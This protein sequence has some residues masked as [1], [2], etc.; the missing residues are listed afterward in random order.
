M[1]PSSLNDTFRTISVRNSVVAGMSLSTIVEAQTLSNVQGAIG[2]VELVKTVS[3]WMT[4]TILTKAPIIQDPKDPSAPHSILKQPAGI[5]FRRCGEEVLQKKSQ[6]EKKFLNGVLENLEVLLRCEKRRKLHESENFEVSIIDEKHLLS[7]PKDKRK[8]NT[9]LG[10]RGV[11]AKQ[12]IRAGSP[13]VYSAQY[14]NEDQWFA[15]VQGL[16]GYLAIEFNLCPEDACLEAAQRLAAYAFPIVEFQSEVFRVP[17]YGAGNVCVMINHDETFFNMKSFRPPLIDEKGKPVA[18]VT[19]YY[20]C[21][22]IEQGEQLLVNYG[23]KYKIQR[24]FE[25]REAVHF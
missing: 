3:P 11:I 4:D 6:R 13:V 24:F 8:L 21:R 10:L 14:M 18:A 9:T 7:A 12:K 19:V 17:A 15:A 16:A 2:C 20:T 25:K 22:D 23:D 1:H 5:N